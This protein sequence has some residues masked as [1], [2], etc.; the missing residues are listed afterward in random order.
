MFSPRPRRFVSGYRTHR[1][2]LQ[3]RSFSANAAVRSHVRAHFR[4]EYIAKGIYNAR[5]NGVVRHVA[6]NDGDPE[7]VVFLTLEPLNRSAP[8]RFEVGVNHNFREIWLRS[9]NRIYKDLFDQSEPRTGLFD[10]WWMAM[11]RSTTASRPIR[12]VR[13]Q[14]S[15]RLRFYLCGFA[16]RDGTLLS[17]N[18]NIDVNYSFSI[19]TEGRATPGQILID[20]E[21]EVEYRF[22]DELTQRLL[23]EKSILPPVFC[24]PPL[25][26]L[27]GQ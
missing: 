24:A 10:R 20:G 25:F 12:F 8:S 1:F 4:P 6:S 21:G 13:Q 14:F 2:A 16:E 23:I 15:R 18:W 9:L 7:R 17:S 19:A 5:N 26:A 11:I 3:L 27:P 22:D